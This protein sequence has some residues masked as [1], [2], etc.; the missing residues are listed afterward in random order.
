MSSFFP[1][2]SRYAL[3]ETATMTMPDGTEVRY[4]RRR[5][6]PQPESLAEIG[7]RT[8]VQGDRLDLIAYRELG[9]AEQAWRV[10]DANG[11][12]MPADVPLPIGRRLR[13]TLPEG[14]PGAPRA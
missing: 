10:A 7:S 11:A 2:T 13:I 8:T 14:I 3:T 9:D 4:L 6:L 12:M 1:P 5:F